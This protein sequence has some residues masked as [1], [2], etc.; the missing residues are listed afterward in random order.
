[1]YLQH[2]IVSSSITSVI[3]AIRMQAVTVSLAA[4]VFP[5]DCAVNEKTPQQLPN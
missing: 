5:E 3:L 1:M 2:R 4:D